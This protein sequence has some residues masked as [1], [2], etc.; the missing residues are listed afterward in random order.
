MVRRHEANVIHIDF[1]D[2]SIRLIRHDGLASVSVIERS[3]TVPV[4]EQADE[5]QR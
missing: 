4:V 1:E 2:R 5:A 3:A